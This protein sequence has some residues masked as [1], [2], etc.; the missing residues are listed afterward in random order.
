MKKF[1]T[2]LIG[3]IY[4]S[5]WVMFML[6]FPPLITSL[7]GAAVLLY[8]VFDKLEYI[9]YAFLVNVVGQ[10]NIPSLT[11]LFSYPLTL[12]VITGWIVG[13]QIGKHVVNYYNGSAQ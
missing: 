13:D 1:E 4:L 12:Q 3:I 9:N 8:Y 5:S 10:T 6:A 2:L 11:Y 7:I